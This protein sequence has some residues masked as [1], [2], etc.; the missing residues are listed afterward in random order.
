MRNAELEW[1]DNGA[2]RSSRFGEAYYSKADG[3]AASEHVFLAHNDLPA[4]FERLSAAARHFTIAETGFGTGLNFLLAWRAFTRQA[5]AGTQLHYLSAEAFPLSPADLGRA[6]AAWPELAALAREL[7]EAYPPAV[8][9]THRLVLAGGRVRLTLLFGDAAACY[10]SVYGGADGLVDAWFLDGFAPEKNPEMWSGRLFA[11]MARLSKPG[12]SFSSFT[13]AGGVRR[14]LQAVGFEVRKAPGFA[15]PWGMSC[16]H[17]PAPEKRRAGAPWFTWPTTALNARQATVIGGG[18]AGSASAHALAE[19][20]WQITLIERHEELAQEASGNRAGALYPHLHA[21]Y[22][23]TTRL[24]LSSYLYALRQI[25][26]LRAQGHDI[27]GAEDGVVL[28]AHDEKRA[29]QLDRLLAGLQLPESVL[30]PTRADDLPFALERAGLIFPGG[31]WLNP[32]ALC[33]AYSAHPNIRV[34]RA[35]EVLSWQR[36]G[37]AWQVIDAKGCRLATTPVLILATGSA[38]RDQLWSRELP[39]D[40]VRGQVSHVACSP[41]S[42]AIK[43]VLCYEGYMTPAWQGTHCLGASFERGVFD[44]VTTER[45]HEENREKLRT[46]LPA[47]A[48]SLKPAAEGRVAYRLSCR[49]H[50]PLVGA[51]PDFAGFRADFRELRRGFAYEHYPPARWQDGLYLNIAHGSRGLTT[52]PLSAELLA[53]TICGEPLPLSAELAESVAVPRFLIRELQKT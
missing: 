17:F 3:L 38:T 47:L 31:G 2:P 35:T 26:H 14:G 29:E 41:L 44:K 49:D 6:L 9:G 13:V 7:V 42:A 22:S 5:P 52:A 1:D 19:R 8:A 18:L 25:A 21:S 30:R 37:D 33:R 43:S 36:N 4:R 16:G 15:P 46:A 28:L 40:A 20:G 48:E 10:A 23:P 51:I 45:E 27:P 39:L 12:A 53:A 11:E 50:L 32:P 34:L 24:F